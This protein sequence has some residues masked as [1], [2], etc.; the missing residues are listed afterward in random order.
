[1]QV[2]EEVQDLLNALAAQRDI[3]ANGEA[4][5]SA[6]LVAANRRIDRLLGEIEALKR[7]EKPCP[8]SVPSASAD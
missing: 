5:V 3:H 2:S 8:S 1:M 7:E 6:A 4:Q